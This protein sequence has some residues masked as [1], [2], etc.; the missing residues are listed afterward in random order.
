ML[1]AKF[2]IVGHS[3]EPLI[4]NGEIV[5]VSN[6]FY[7]FKNPQIGDIV[8]FREIEKTLIK[9]VTQVKGKKYFLEGDNMEDSLDSRK[10]GLISK[11]NIIG[12]VFYKL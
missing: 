4:K 11:K 5:L 1:F 12:K 2:K 3:M 6:I 8:A 9:R 10:F 7:L